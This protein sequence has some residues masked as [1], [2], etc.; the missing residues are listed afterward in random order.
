MSVGPGTLTPTSSPESVVVKF[1]SLL[2]GIGSSGD[3][4]NSDSSLSNK[5]PLRVSREVV[6]EV[7]NNDEE[8]VGTKTGTITYN[9]ATGRFDGTVDLGT[10]VVP[11]NYLVKVK[12]PQ[13]LRE[14]F[15][16]ITS[17]GRGTNNLPTVT[18][19]SGDVNGDNVLN[20][21]DYNFILGCYSDLTPAKACDAVQKLNTDLDDDGKVNQR[22]Y[23]L[24][25]REVAGRSGS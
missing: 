22:D 3:S 19:I 14:S 23:N 5:S 21:L 18:F 9:S 10:S 7:F 20:I 11:G 25:L 24:F 13:F 1:T 2:H 8:I 4:V 12:T 6:V 16:G 17:L 15:S